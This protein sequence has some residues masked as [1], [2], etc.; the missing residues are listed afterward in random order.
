MVAEQ[1]LERIKKL[2]TMLANK[3]SDYQRWLEVAEGLG[4]GAVGE[5]V[6]TS[7]NLH[8][9]PDA[10]GAYVD[11]DN[12]I[13]R[14]REERLAIIKTIERLPPLEY[15]LIYRLYVQDQT[16]KELAFH[17]KKS[18]DTVKRWKTHALSL[19]QYMLDEAQTSTEKR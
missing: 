16:M 14:L 6:K 8:Q 11:I 5:R 13:C 9:I 3:L 12:E 15:D 17:F 10:I 18:Y 19:V 2:D 4:G 1:Y 7:R